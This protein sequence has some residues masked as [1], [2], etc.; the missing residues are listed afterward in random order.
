MGTRRS[1]RA[2]AGVSM[3]SAKGLVRATVAVAARATSVPT[4]D[5]EHEKVV[6]IGANVVADGSVISPAGIVIV[7]AGQGIYDPV[8]FG[9]Y[10]R[11][12]QTAFP[13]EPEPHTLPTNF[14]ICAKQA[15][16]YARLSKN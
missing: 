11:A 8:L 15:H 9:L 3:K 2:I 7:P 13:L 10:D 16:L 1:W 14:N 6:S 5:P 12:S 4:Y